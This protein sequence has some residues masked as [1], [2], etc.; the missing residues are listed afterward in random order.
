MNILDIIR[1]KIQTPKNVL[2]VIAKFNED[3]TWVKQLRY[4]Y[5]IYDKSKDIP[6]VG[7]EAETY[8]RYIIENYTT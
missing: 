7:R 3:I 5:K 2:I 6:N 8:L 1:N 4:N